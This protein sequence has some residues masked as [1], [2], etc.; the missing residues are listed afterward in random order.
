MLHLA[1]F[2]TDASAPIIDLDRSHV[3][4]DVNRFEK[5]RK[6]CPIATPFRI[7]HRGDVIGVGWVFGDRSQ[8]DLAQIRAG[9]AANPAVYPGDIIYVDSTG[10]P[11]YLRD[12]LQGL[13]TIAIFARLM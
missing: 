5:R 2:E 7:P 13:S 6:E 11:P 8:H 4:P 12:L 1:I 9:K 3:C 10:A